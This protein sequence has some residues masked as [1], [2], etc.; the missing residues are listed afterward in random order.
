MRAPAR[1][2]V[3]RPG[4]RATGGSALNRSPCRYKEVVDLPRRLKMQEREVDPNKKGVTLHP[5]VQ[6]S[7]TRV[8]VNGLHAWVSCPRLLPRTIPQLMRALKSRLTGAFRGS[9]RWPDVP[10]NTTDHLP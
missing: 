7:D 2:L 3:W 8:V 10:A 1:T 9:V 4:R 6:I 5:P